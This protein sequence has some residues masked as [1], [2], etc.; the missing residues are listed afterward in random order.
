MSTRGIKAF[1][2]YYEKVFGQRWPS[3]REALQAPVCQVA[4]LNKFADQAAL[5]KKFPATKRESHRGVEW[6]ELSSPM[7]PEADKNGLLDFYRMDLA[8]VFPAV[9]LDVKSGE[10]VLDMCAAPG[11]KTLILAEQLGDAGD[12]IANEIS[13]NRRS[14]LSRVIREYVPASQIARVKLTAH[15]ASR[16]CLYEKD[17]FDKI[18]LDAP[19]SGERHLLED[20]TEMKTWSEARSK[21]LAVRQYGLLASAIQAVKPG[22]LVVYSTC[23]LSV[24][25]NDEIIARLMKRRAGEARVVTTPAPIGE[26]T[27]HGW[28]ILPDKSR[29]GP[30][31]FT[32]LERI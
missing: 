26:A 6:V 11:G 4:R 22:G 12:L 27:E 14:R 13:D 7:E 10:R 2:G 24:R 18:L 30:I 17:A 23:S 16:W 29:F 3:L 25:E 5:L 8:S 21:N 28:M 31:Y 20:E 9:A 19:C 15:D 32:V 1:D